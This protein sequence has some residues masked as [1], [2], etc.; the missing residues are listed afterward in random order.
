MEEFLMNVCLPASLCTFLVV[1]LIHSCKDKKVKVEPTHE[2]KIEKYK[3][4]PD[5]QKALDMVPCS[6][7]DLIFTFCDHC[8]EP[9]SPT[10]DWVKDYCLNCQ[11]FKKCLKE[12][13]GENTVNS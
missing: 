4:T 2:A 13:Q 3:P 11:L 10:G 9:S 8:N 5:E 12:V 1:F 7:D 6:Y